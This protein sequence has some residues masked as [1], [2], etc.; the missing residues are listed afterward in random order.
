[1]AVGGV[2]PESVWL[3]VEQYADIVGIEATPHSFRHHFASRLLT[4]GASVA[5]VQKL[6]GHSSVAVTTKVYWHAETDALAAVYA[7]FSGGRPALRLVQLE[8]TRRRRVPGPGAPTPHRALHGGPEGVGAMGYEIRDVDG[9][10]EVTARCERCGNV[11][12][13]ATAI[14]EHWG[15]AFPK[16]GEGC[17]CEDR[18]LLEQGGSSHLIVDRG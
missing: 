2:E 12:P 9:G 13:V 1:M 8:Y 5:D 18:P 11:S 10:T 17:A 4:A 16:R 3:I 6:M 15:H 14:G 7:R